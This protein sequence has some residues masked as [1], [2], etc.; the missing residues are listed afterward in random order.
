M[1]GRSSPRSTMCEPNIYEI[2]IKGHLSGHWSDWFEDM[3]ITLEE[4]GHTVLT[5]SMVDDAALHGMLKRV[6][7]AGMPLISVNRIKP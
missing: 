5:G 4:D 1:S 2:R 7:D 3:A 6:R